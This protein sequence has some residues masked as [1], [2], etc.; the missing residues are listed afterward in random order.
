MAGDHFGEEERG[1]LGNTMSGLVWTRSILPRTAPIPALAPVMTTVLLRRRLALKT[2][3]V[4]GGVAFDQGL[5]RT[6]T[7]RSSG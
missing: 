3:I 2:D 1:G 6:E 5:S 7:W 4:R